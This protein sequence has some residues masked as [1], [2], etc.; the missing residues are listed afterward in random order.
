MGEYQPGERVE[1]NIS[2]GIVPDE[3]TEPEPQW[4]PGTVLERMPSGL[5]RIQLDHPIGGRLAEKEAAP[6]HIRRLA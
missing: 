2:A 4:E 3:T 1:V 6:E 5:Y